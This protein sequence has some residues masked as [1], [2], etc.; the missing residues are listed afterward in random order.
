MPE[1][2]GPRRRRNRL[3]D[4]DYSAAGAYFVTIVTHHREPMLGDVADT[5]MNLSRFG[6]VADSCW[7]ELP[8]HYRHASLDAWI[9]MPNHVH[10]V[11]VLAEDGGGTKRHGIPEIVRGFKTFSARRINEH[12]NTP[13]LPVW[14]RSYYDHIIRDDVDLHDVRQY[15][16]RNPAVWADDRENRPYS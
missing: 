3:P 1:D 8:D 5:V 2:P 15:I 4:Y 10:G 14:Q 6:E 12:R 11:I 13:G 16:D 9:V 7:R